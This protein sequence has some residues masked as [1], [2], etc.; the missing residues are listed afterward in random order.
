MITVTIAE[1]AQFIDELQ[2]DATN[3]VAYE[4][5]VTVIH[6]EVMQER[7]GGKVSGPLHPL[8]LRVRGRK[9]WQQPVGL[10]PRIRVRG[11]PAVG[12]FRCW[13]RLA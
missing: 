8:R 9:R 10:R 1:D 4:G 11:P 12:D 3:V 2:F 13:A 6:R 7:A 5:A